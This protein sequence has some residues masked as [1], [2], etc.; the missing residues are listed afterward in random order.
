MLDLNKLPTEPTNAKAVWWH[1]D[2]RFGMM[3]TECQ[4]FADKS[5]R[6]LER[7]HPDIVK[8]V[9]TK[10]RANLADGCEMQTDWMSDDYSVATFVGY[11][12]VFPCKSWPP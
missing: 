6:S 7:N 9:M 8:S 12:F 1:G 10:Y 5:P 2:L 11:R 3:H 4:A